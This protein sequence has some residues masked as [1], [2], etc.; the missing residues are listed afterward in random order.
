MTWLLH[1]LFYG[2]SNREVIGSAEW[3]QASTPLPGCHMGL[4][5]S[6]PSYQPWSCDKR[7]LDESGHR[8]PGDPWNFLETDW[9]LS[10][11]HGLEKSEHEWTAGWNS[12]PTPSP[13]LAG[14]KALI[15]EIRAIL[16]C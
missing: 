8:F 12:G 10:A 7:L 3:L 15:S 11:G 14:F 13:R 2:F 9:A 6:L 4:P 1:S 5:R 16:S